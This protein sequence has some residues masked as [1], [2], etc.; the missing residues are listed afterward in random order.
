MTTRRVGSEE[1]ELDADPRSW[2]SQ[3]PPAVGRR[4]PRE[5]LTARI[6]EVLRIDIIE[7]ILGPG[8]R[9][10]VESLAQDYG[11]SPTPIREALQR[12]AAENF[13]T[14]DPRVG[15]SVAQ[16][17]AR[18][19]REVY[20]MRDL[21]ECAALRRSI[22]VGDSQWEETVRSSWENFL[23]LLAA[24]RTDILSWA[25]VH[26]AFHAATLSGAGSRWLTHFVSMLQNQSERYRILSVKTASR[27]SLAEHRS[28]YDAVI[29]RDPDAAVE[30]HR[31]HLLTTVE[32]LEPGLL[33]QAAVTDGQGS[34]DAA[35]RVAVGGSAT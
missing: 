35:E 34:D 1:G 20:W 22:E 16:L 33:A 23:P 15:A 9:L 12:L 24:G 10:R 29:A 13:V 21:L 26:R 28:I 18:E 25:R 6:E 5:T 32:L 27:D 4:V 8:M 11:V 3:R 14:L 2:P 30:A 7:G 19:L 31:N 17:S